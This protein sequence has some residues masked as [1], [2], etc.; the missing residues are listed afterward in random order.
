[1]NEQSWLVAHIAEHHPSA[2]ASVV[3]GLAAARVDIAPIVSEA[4]VSAPSMSALAE[5]LR[6]DD[7]GLFSFLFSGLA[8]GGKVGAVSA[9]SVPT[10]LRVTVGYAGGT[11]RRR[12]ARG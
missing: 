1:M 12:P 6:F 7:I 9:I 10:S 11:H 8:I 5:R 3:A 4:S 2:V